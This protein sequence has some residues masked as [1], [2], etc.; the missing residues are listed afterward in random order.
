MRTKIVACLA[1]LAA[2][3]AGGFVA[4]QTGLVGAAGVTSGYRTVAPVRIFDSRDPGGNQPL[5]T[6]GRQ[7]T[8]FTGQTG[9][10][11]VGVN[12][13]LTATAGPGFVTA[14]ASGP[15][16]GTAII[17]S[18]Q[19]DEN[20][21]NFAI[22]PVAPDGSFQ[23]Y[24][25][26]PTHIVVDL[27]GGFDVTAAPIAANPPATTSP[28]TTTPPPTGSVTVAITG[29]SPATTITSIVGSVTN[30]SNITRSI[31]VDVRCPNGSVETDSFFSLAAGAT[32]GWSVL[33]TGVFSSGA[34]ATTID[35]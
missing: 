34:T 28:T 26:N 32:K 13:A 17:N 10:S 5:L 18:T 6:A 9:S 35:I 21:S 12:I 2:S 7:V 23:L 29:Y 1:L 19:A 30:G 8:V 11:A 3:F 15:R 4:Q 22:V 14:W 24:T 27:L 16:P 25:L 31:R 20:I 33:C